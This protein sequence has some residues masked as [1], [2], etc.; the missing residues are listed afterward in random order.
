MPEYSVV[1]E[2]EA[3][4]PDVDVDASAGELPSFN[5]EW[6]DVDIS[7]TTRMVEVPVVEV[8][9]E[10]REVEVPVIDVAMPGESTDK[11]E[12]TLL[13]EAELQDEMHNLSIE[14][15][16]AVDGRFLV[17]SSLEATG[18]PLERPQR[19]SDRLI[20]NAPDLDV[21]HYIIGDQPPGDF[22]NQYTYVDDISAIEGR[23]QDGRIVY[24]N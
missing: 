6:A 21:K 20:L 19:V 7:T 12:R 13:V 1:Q 11:Q 15:V 4:V 10:L 18:E 24:Q 14:R 22:N 2:E 9:T 16:Y 17:I 23:L 3:E 8:T 5:V